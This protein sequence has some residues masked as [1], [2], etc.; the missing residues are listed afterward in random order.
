MRTK[1]ILC[2][3]VVGAVSFSGWA[4]GVDVPGGSFRVGV[5]A[6]ALPG[7]GAGLRLGGVYAGEGFEA[8][9]TSRVALVP[10]VRFVQEAGFAMFPGELS[11]G[12][13]LEVRVVPFVL[14]VA[15]VWART[16]LFETYLG[17]SDVTLIG[18]VGAEMWF[19][20][21]FGGALSAQGVISV[22]GGIPVDLISVT[23]VTYDQVR[24]LGLEEQLEIRGRFRS[25][26]SDGASR[27]IHLAG[28]LTV[29]ARLD[30]FGLQIPRIR[31]ALDVVF[32]WARSGP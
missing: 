14:D 2:L 19:G 4:Q 30:A 12:I 18:G 6:S 22:P 10:I 24:G 20:A 8:Y 23:G 21:Q 3:L 26:A 25:D 9:A 27:G 16:E 11:V 5:E 7:F 31:V 17:R 15:D 1:I 29:D 28:I 32:P 13:D